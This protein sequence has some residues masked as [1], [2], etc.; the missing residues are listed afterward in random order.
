MDISTI[1][2][3]VAALVLLI[4]MY[5]KVPEAAH[6]GLRAPVGSAKFSGSESRPK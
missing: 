4:A 1:V 6:K 3:M 2:M 5:W